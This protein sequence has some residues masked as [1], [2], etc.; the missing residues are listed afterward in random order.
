MAYD[1]GIGTSTADYNSI[2]PYAL[3]GGQRQAQAEQ[4]VLSFDQADSVGGLLGN[5]SQAPQVND[6][7]LPVGLE[8]IAKSIDNG[9]GSQQKLFTSI[10]QAV[11]DNAT[12]EAIRQKKEAYMSAKLDDMARMQY[13]KSLLGNLANGIV[14]GVG[15]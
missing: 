14:G 4:P 8:S 11:V 13:A 12:E 5:I 7:G 10:G 3:V 2:R 1:A 9:E 15:Y 6:N